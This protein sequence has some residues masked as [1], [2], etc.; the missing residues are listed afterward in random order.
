MRRFRCQTISDV[1]LVSAA[2]VLANA[3][4][5]TTLANFSNNTG[6]VPS[7]KTGSSLVQGPD[8]NFYGTAKQQG[9]NDLGTIFKMTPD[10]T[11][12]TLYSFTGQAD[13]FNPTSGL[14]LGSDGNLYGTNQSAIFKITPGG[15]F[16]TLYNADAPVN[17]VTFSFGA[18]PA[19]VSYDGLAA[20]F[21]GLYEFYITVPSGLAGGD[22]QINVTQNGTALPQIMY[23]TVQNAN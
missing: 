22:Y 6:A 19:T 14:I 8:G 2:A 18:A 17:P 23:L 21:V 7:G 20:S 10:G 16:T 5:F 12:T 9:A 15:A 13:G 1:L 4:T 3:Q 11:L